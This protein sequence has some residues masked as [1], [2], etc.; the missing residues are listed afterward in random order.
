MT[1]DSDLLLTHEW[2]DGP[3]NRLQM[4]LDV[5]RCIGRLGRMTKSEQVDDDHLMIRCEA[6][7]LRLP[8]PSRSSKSVEKHDW[9]ARSPY[10]HMQAVAEVAG[11]AVV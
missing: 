10:S 4:L 6:A 3:V 1:G 8:V 9:S 11:A 5:I 7:N 2:F